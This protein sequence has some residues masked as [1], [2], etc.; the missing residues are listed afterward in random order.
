MS[1]AVI[2]VHIITC[3][4]SGPNET[5]T[6]GVARISL[7]PLQIT[8]I[9]FLVDHSACCCGFYPGVHGIAQPEC[10]QSAR[11]VHVASADVVA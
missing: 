11:N 4:F 1:D 5:S 3:V 6:V 10:D 7:D 9:D 2:Y 8:F